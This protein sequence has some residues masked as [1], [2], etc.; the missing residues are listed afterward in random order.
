MQ[1]VWSS[2]K[3]TRVRF[4]TL[5]IIRRTAM[6]RLAQS[7]IALSA[8]VVCLLVL[9]HAAG[10]PIV[11]CIGST[12][13][14]AVEAFESSC[15]SRVSCASPALYAGHPECGGCTDLPIETISQK[16]GPRT[17]THPVPLQAS[18]ETIEPVHSRFLASLPLVIASRIA[19][20]PGPPP[21]LR[22]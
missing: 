15:C 10:L 16:D 8:L 3:D 22:C 11:L 17:T 4:G 6:R 21:L 12:G 19:P 20:P 18:T 2:V 9:A 1:P 5:E 13:H 7:E 14:I